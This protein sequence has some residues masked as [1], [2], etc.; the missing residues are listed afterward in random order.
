MTTFSFHH[1]SPVTDLRFD[2]RKIDGEDP[3]KEYFLYFLDYEDFNGLPSGYVYVAIWEFLAFLERNNLTIEPE[4]SIGRTNDGAPIY[5]VS[6][7]LLR[8]ME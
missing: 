5:A 1:F 7:D 3:N 2:Y 4:M 8:E 6:R